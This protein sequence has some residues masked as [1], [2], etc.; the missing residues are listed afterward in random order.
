MAIGF[1]STVPEVI[2][3]WKGWHVGVTGWS[4]SHNKLLNSISTYYM[5]TDTG[6]P[7]PALLWLTGHAHEMLWDD[8]DGKWVENGSDMVSAKIFPRFITL[9]R[10]ATG[11]YRTKYDGALQVRTQDSII[12]E[13]GKTVTEAMTWM[14]P[15]GYEGTVLSHTRE[16]C[17]EIRDMRGNVL[18]RPDFGQRFTIDGFTMYQS[19]SNSSEF[20]YGHLQDATGGNL[21]LYIPIPGEPLDQ[22]IE[23]WNEYYYRQ[24]DY[25]IESRQLQN[26]KQLVQSLSN[27]GSSAM[28]GAIGGEMAGM[29]AGLG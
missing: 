10:M 15:G 27:V 24:R 20:A 26:Q 8:D 11:Q 6:L 28:G 22:V 21:A 2:S 29:G 3:S 1:D 4:S 14:I 19:I 7:N 9:S 5:P 16:W 18:F 13:E 12:I 23:T 17:D 25:D